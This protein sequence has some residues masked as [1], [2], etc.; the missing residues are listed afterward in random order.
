M[1]GRHNGNNVY[2]PSACDI[3]F[4][5]SPILKLLRV[6]VGRRETFYKKIETLVECH[7]LLEC[8][9]ESPGEIGIY[10]CMRAQIYS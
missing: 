9:Q 3:L 5:A 1:N 4:I 8:H 6:Q 10:S 2:S 7:E